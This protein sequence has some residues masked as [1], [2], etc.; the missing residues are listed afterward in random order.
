MVKNIRH[1]GKNPGGN[2]TAFSIKKFKNGMND[3]IRMALIIVKKEVDQTFQ[4]P[5]YVS[6][7]ILSFILLS[8]FLFPHNITWS[9]SFSFKDIMVSS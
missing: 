5:W 7:S 6:V 1:Y 9:R 4:R 3:G 8:K 2:T